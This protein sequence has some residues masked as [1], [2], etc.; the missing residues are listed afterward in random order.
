MNHKKI[1]TFQK[2]INNVIISRDLKP[3][4]FG[5]AILFFVCDYT[6]IFYT[7][8]LCKFNKINTLAKESG[9][10]RERDDRH[11]C[12]MQFL[13]SAAVQNIYTSDYIFVSDTNMCY[14]L[15]YVI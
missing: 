1:E 5:Y 15:Y 13:F 6:F 3:M 12:E 9:G 10:K 11:T 7:Q 4:G 14:Y 8:K 2:T